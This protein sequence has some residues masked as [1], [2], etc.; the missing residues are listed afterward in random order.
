MAEALSIKRRKTAT[1]PLGFDNLRSEAIKQVQQLSGQ[2][3]TDY[4]LHD[5]GITILEQ[6]IYSVTDLIYRTDFDVEDLLADEDGKINL[7]AQSLYE[8]AEIFPCRATTVL[9]Y[10]KLLFDAVP[11][12][13]N[14]W[15]SDMAEQAVPGQCRGLYRLEVKLMQ[16][17]DEPARK[18]ALDRICTAYLSARNLC[19][20]LGEI[21]I[22]YT[23]E[24][25]LCADIEVSSARDPADILA[26]IYF[27]CARRIASSVSITGYDQ[28]ADQDQ[29]LDQLFDGPFTR[30]GFFKTEDM[31]EHQSEYPV[32]TLIST[33]NS[34]EGV[35]HIRQMYLARDGESFY[36]RIGPI[37][38]DQAFDL[39]F[40]RSVEDIKV[41]LTTNGRELPIAL[42][43]LTARYNQIT[44]KYHTSRSTP[45]DLSLLYK[46]V[47]GVSRPLTQYYSI[48]NHFPLSY[49]I[50]SL[51]VPATAPTE[52]KAKARQLKAYLL[53]FEQLLINFLANL[54]SAKVLFSTQIEPRTSYATRA[55]NG[56]QV[57]DL[58]AV[59]PPDPGKVFSRVVASFDH[60]NE[61]KSRLLDYLLA[62]YGERFSQNSLRHF[63]FYDNAA[64]IE[65]VIVANKIAY[66]ESIVELGRDR[67]AAPD[68]SASPTERR[69][70]GLALRVSMLLGFEQRQAPSLVAAIREQDTELSPHHD[71][72]QL[73]ADSDE[74]LLID[75]GEA[76]E[77]SHGSFEQPSLSTLDKNVSLQTVRDGIADIL[78]LKSGL[79][80]EFLLRE[81]IHIER[82]RVGRLNAA[83]E[84]QL[85]FQIDQN[86][87]WQL[88]S[89]PD[90]SA[91]VQATN[92]LRQFLILLNRNSEGLYIVEHIL[93]RP[94]SQAAGQLPGTDHDEDLFSF[95]VSVIFP[96]WTARCHD[97]QFRLLAEETLRLNLPAHV[98]PEFYWLEFAQMS[99]FETLN[100]RWLEQKSDRESSATEID[101]SAQQ[102]ISFLL[103]QRAARRSGD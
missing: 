11:E 58:D 62:L 47:T 39:S 28:F 71:Y 12:I 94:Q 6:L 17:L 46:P 18:A 57:H 97:Q 76:G 95:R 1:I 23:L 77:S 67:A 59:Y 3:W 101:H 26:E 21:I 34:I 102:L 48:Q 92:D 70:S 60:Y 66:L 27:E 44:F 68:Y 25:E 41:V 72:Q 63:N 16:G 38:T 37:G 20:D 69:G 86:R 22:F 55:L 31:R 19:E 91:A 45:Q 32:S 15:L 74:L 51:G 103:D 85:I 5:P 61:R 88:G 40:P 29:S 75:L 4:N 52:V 53:N 99:E 43:E 24:Y 35:N 8:P 54:D 83:Q 87:Y 98:Y 93:L 82:Y 73:K 49:G 79:L 96:G 14:V 9:D 13:D 7:E 64:E 56:Q 36:D 2:I 89:Y 50:N 65:S 78:A 100:E 90:K 30:H 81:G 80:S 33:I 84:Y 42:N 10:R